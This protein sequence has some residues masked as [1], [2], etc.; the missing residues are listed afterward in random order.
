MHAFRLNKGAAG[1]SRWI[2]LVVLC[3]GMLMIVLDQTIVNVALPAIQRDFGFSQSGHKSKPLRAM[4]ELWALRRL[5]AHCG[6]MR[7]VRR[8]ARKAGRR[9]QTALWPPPRLED[10]S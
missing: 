3:V 5:G 1:R 8:R 6:P 2:A 10:R 4:A 9:C 7:R